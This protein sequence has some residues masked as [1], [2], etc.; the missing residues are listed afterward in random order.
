MKEKKQI[1]EKLPN[2]YSSMNNTYSQSSQS[3]SKR[4]EIIEEYLL[5]MEKKA[6]GFN[7]ISLT[8]EEDDKDPFSSKAIK[9]LKP[10]K[11]ETNKLILP[12][13]AKREKL[14]NQLST[15]NTNIKKNNNNSYSNITNNNTN[16]N[17]NNINNYIKQQVNV[18]NDKNT[19]NKMTKKTKN[20]SEH[21]IY[22][23]NNN[24]INNNTN[25]YL[26]K[27]LN[28]NNNNLN[29]KWTTS[30]NTYNKYINGVNNN[31]FNKNI[32]KYK[33]NYNNN[34]NNNNNNNT[35]NSTKN[36]KEPK[37]RSRSHIGNK[38]SYYLY[39]EKN[40]TFLNAKGNSST[41]NKKYISTQVDM[42]QKN[43]NCNKT[44][45]NNN[46]EPKNYKRNFTAK[47]LK[48]K[49][50][51]ILENNKLYKKGEKTRVYSTLS[52]RRIVENK[53]QIYEKLINEKNNPYGLGWINKMLG[54][55]NEEK[56]GITRGF[57]NGVPV[58]KILNKVEL[59]KRE[60][61]KRLSE[62][63]RKKKEEENKN[64]KIINAQAKMNEG[65]LDDEYNIPKEILEQFNKNTKNFYK[66]RKDIIEE[67][68]EEEEQ[69]TSQKC[70]D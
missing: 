38:P 20:Y 14:K 46:F 58:V 2:I 48:N 45:K 35:N 56:L 15:R 6:N 57:I 7:E 53:H 43:F 16:N 68:E 70:N 28:N 26:G 40:N 37:G 54:K 32:N 44:S 61:K 30:S 17:N 22:G 42:L 27:F 39:N 41:H 25:L 65:E 5:S 51:S 47:I 13:F 23:N 29:S 50:I 31:I 34:S 21:N 69:L 1:E 33:V 24:N 4:N 19:H 66:F 60:I 10:L 12:N 8:S 36:S 18:K 3:I 11:K 62:I 59:S 64:N 63:E 9:N 52:T 67:P 49:K 55:N